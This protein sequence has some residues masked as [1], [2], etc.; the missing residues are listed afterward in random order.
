MNVSLAKVF[1]NRVCL[2]FRKRLQ[3]LLLICLTL[4]CFSENVCVLKKRVV[5]KTSQRTH[6]FSFNFGQLTGEHRKC[7]IT[8]VDLELGIW[9]KDSC[10]ERV[11]QTPITLMLYTNS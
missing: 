11:I 3:T 6:G 1:K 7:C 5:Q 2:Y 4:Q 8:Q 10:F 9:C